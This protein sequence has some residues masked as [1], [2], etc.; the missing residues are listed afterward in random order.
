VEPDFVQHA[1]EI[2][3]PSDFFV[4]TAQAWNLWHTE[5]PHF[6]GAEILS[7]LW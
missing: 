4:A 7:M 6:A 2:N 5:A 1:A 3:Q